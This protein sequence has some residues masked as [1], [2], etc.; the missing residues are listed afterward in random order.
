MP[1]MTIA[2][3][4]ETEDQLFQELED[5]GFTCLENAIDPEFLAACRKQIDGLLDERGERFFTIIQPQDRE[6]GAF[7]DMASTPGFVDL[8]RNLARRGHSKSAVEGFELYNVLRIIANGGEEG[9]FEFHY[10]ATVVTML[11]P[12]YIPEG[13]PGT[14]GE[15]IAMPNRRR[16]RKSAVISIL[17]KLLLQNPIAFRYYR[18]RYGPGKRNAVQLKPGNLYFFWGYRTFHGN[19]PCKQ[20]H[21]RATL[22]FHFGDPHAGNRLTQGVLKIRKFREERRLNAA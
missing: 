1:T 14:T 9:A 6:G 3:D 17:E 13:A 10:D 8:L 4:L 21:K 5:K 19:L 18:W 7:A 22:I 20:G 16:Y 12:L 15:L 11:M 2:M